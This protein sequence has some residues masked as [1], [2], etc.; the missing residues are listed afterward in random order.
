MN[1][2]G[3]GML[4]KSMAG[5]DREKIYMIKEV[6][7]EYVYLVDGRLRQLEHPKKK[8]RKHVQIIKEQYPVSKMDDVQIRRILKKWN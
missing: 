1:G 5:H 7:G 4:A 3:I 8:K 6:C 2:Y